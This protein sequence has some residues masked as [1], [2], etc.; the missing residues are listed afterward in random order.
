VP[1]SQLPSPET[2]RSNQHLHDFLRWVLK[3]IK[4]PQ[5]PRA[6]DFGCGSGDLTRLL[7]DHFGASAHIL[8][9]DPKSKSIRAARART[10]AS[11]YPQIEFRTIQAD[12]FPFRD[13]DFD[14]AF[15]ARA[16]L[17]VEDPQHIFNELA[18]LL[19]PRGQLLALEMDLGGYFVSEVQQ[20]DPKRLPRMNPYVARA[21]PTLMLEAGLEPSD[22]F[23]NFVVSREP[24]TRDTLE[25]KTAGLK[26][27]RPRLRHLERLEFDDYVRK[28]QDAVAAQTK[29]YYSTLL[30]VAVLG[31]KRVP[32][33]G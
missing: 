30:E 10:D 32:G 21:L 2:S 1:P 26:T 7:A 20:L 22:L 6:L 14:F 18:R 13:G 17:D 33:D 23:P 19:K 3:K 24:L 27:L 5:S 15:C 8:A 4:L 9:I 29:G 31:R 28:L 25:Q 16:L 12:A 11:Q